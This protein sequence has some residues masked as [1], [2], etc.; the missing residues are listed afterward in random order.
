MDGADPTSLLEHSQRT[1][2]KPVDV[3]LV[4]TKPVDVD[5]VAT[6]NTNVETSR[7]TKEHVHDLE[8]RLA[9]M[10]A[11]LTSLQIELAN[12]RQTRIGGQEAVL[13][14]EI[15][16]KDAALNAAEQ[17]LRSEVGA[18]DS[19]LQMVQQLTGA[20]G[21][22]EGR[23]QQQEDAKTDLAQQLRQIHSAWATKAGMVSPGDM[24][25]AMSSALFML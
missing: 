1:P 3:D 11:S 23:M 7:S 10:N 22:L 15:A 14:A 20:I 21:V 25:F 2:P 13:R 12:E 5:L 19:A 4:A 6:S 17:Q 16:A 18:K 24:N 8:E 9:A